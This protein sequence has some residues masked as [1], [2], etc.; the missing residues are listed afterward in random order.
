[1][2]FNIQTAR[3]IN[4]R[5]K[6]GGFNL[7]TAR[8]IKEPQQGISL[9]RKIPVVTRKQDPREITEELIRQRPKALDIL[10]EEVTQP[11]ELRKHPIKTALRPLVTG[12]KAANVPLQAGLSAIANVGLEA[13]EG[14]F[15]PKVLGEAALKGLTGERIGELGDIPR[16]IGVP[17]LISAT[18][19]LF[20]S[21][22]LANAGARKT[23]VKSVNKGLSFIKSKLPK[24]MNKNY[25]LDR[26]RTASGGLDDLY[27]G[28]SKEYD[29]IYDKIGKVQ[30]D[31]KSVQGVIDD[32]PANI[33]NKISKSKLVSKTAS[34]EI[35]PDMNN[36]K[37]IRGIIRKAVPDKVW[38]GKAIGDVNTAD[39]EQSYGKLSNIMAK[40]NPELVDINKR[41]AQFRNMQKTL[42]RI[43]YDA[44]GNVQANSLQ[45]LFS[46]GGERGKQVFF[47][48]FAKQWPQAQQIIKDIGKYNS[49]QGLKSGASKALK[50]GVG[51][52]AARRFVINP[53]LNNYRQ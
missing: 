25:V 1:M 45:R 51:A 27:K 29:A 47:E 23:L 43:L 50:F 30:V 52:E 49:R 53:L 6:S 44:D 26:A 22:P 40:G 38:R 46:K 2:P 8:D 9:K 18:V 15:S 11:W 28:L 10:R 41:Y 5:N 32:L 17:N 48:D 36:L 39:L 21:L 24:I 16:S 33:V 19:G 20:A 7:S 37:I 3:P 4:Q 14:Q 35:V 13:Q 42:G 31:V 34:G 12:L